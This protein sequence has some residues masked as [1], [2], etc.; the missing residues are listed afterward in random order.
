MELQY[1]KID[2]ES[3]A[4][5]LYESDECDRLFA[6]ARERFPGYNDAQAFDALDYILDGLERA[7]ADGYRTRHA[8]SDA[9]VHAGQLR[10]GGRVLLLDIEG[11]R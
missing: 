3:E 1:G 6:A 7:F 5:K 2:L 4:T 11:R 9:G 8:E 10:Q